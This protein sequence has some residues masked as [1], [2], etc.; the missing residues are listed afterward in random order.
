[1][2]RWIA[3]A[4]LCALTAL[5][6]T[7]EEDGK[8]LERLEKLE[9]EVRELKEALKKKD[10][11]PKEVA[12]GKDG[13]GA[14][15]AVVDRVLSRTK[16]GGYFDLEFEDWR[17]AN[18]EFD[19]HHLIV[20]VSSWL[21]ERIFF[22]SEIEYE[23]GARVVKIEQAYLDFLIVDQI[24]FRG[25][26]I[27]VPMGRLNR[28][29]D[30]D[31]RDLTLRPLTTTLITPT[32][33]TEVGVGF[34]GSFYVGSFT[35]NWDAYVTNGLLGNLTTKEGLRPAR[36]GLEKD[37][38]SDKST[39]ARIEVVALGGK[40]T[41][42]AAGYRGRFDNDGKDTV[43]LYGADLTVAVPLGDGGGWIPGPLELRAEAARFTADESRDAA[44]ARSP[45][46]GIGAFAQVSFHFFPPFLKDTFVGMGFEKPTFTL[47]ALWDAVEI[48]A[49]DGPHDNHQRRLSFGFNF[50]PIEQVVFKVEYV[51]EDSDRMFGNFRR[52]GWAASI[53]AAF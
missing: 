24:N 16:V 50:R 12:E 45:H 13:R 41:V 32:T 14:A 7:G 46:R 21:H 39:M 20:Q 19:N 1:M 44:G 10:E 4:A 40:V 25:G 11:A 5:N 9:K 51:D 52:D 37:N 8:A 53:A 31:L 26:A 28:L 29:H 23:H 34:F 48:D 47:V 33:W 38:N 42:G 22:N 6:V 18:S 36:A 35:I 43:L 15:G 2:V 17:H 27:L 3:A 49:P 30:S